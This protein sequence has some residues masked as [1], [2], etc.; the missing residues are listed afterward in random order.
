MAGTREPD[1]HLPQPLID[2]LRRLDRAP[3]VI[4]AR[5]DRTVAATAREHF[6][7]RGA[8]RW[9]RHGAWGAIAACAVLAVALAIGRQALDGE[10]ALYS[11]VD[12]SGR[13][14]IADVLALARSGSGVDEADLDAFAW[15][16]V[17]LN[18]AEAQ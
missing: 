8:R 2:K 1:D 17:A 16:V 12:G 5:V 14:D 10:P 15:R 13:I 6:S 11:D 3:G 9:R 7:V 18:G 4:T